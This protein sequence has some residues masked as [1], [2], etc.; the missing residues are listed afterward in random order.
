[1]D[2]HNL[3][4]RIEKLPRQFQEHILREISICEQAARSVSTVIENSNLRDLLDLEPFTLFPKLRPHDSRIATV[5]NALWNSEKPA[6]P[7]A[8]TLS[9]KVRWSPNH[10]RFLIKSDLNTLLEGSGFFLESKKAKTS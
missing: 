8:D 2:T 3:Q 7:D 5:L 9:K 1:M 6:K 10:L 4:A